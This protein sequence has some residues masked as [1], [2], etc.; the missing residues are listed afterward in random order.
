A[1]ASEIESRRSSGGSATE[2]VLLEASSRP[3]GNIRSTREEG[4]LYEWGPTGFLDNVPETVALAR[5]AGLEHRLTRANPA[6]ER[7]FVVK[8][9]RLCELPH[10]VVGFLLSG[11]L[12]PGGR[13]RVLGEPFVPARRDSSDESVFAFASRRIGREAA[14]VLVDA[15]V[16]GVWAGDSTK[17]SVASAF[18]KLVA[19][20]REHGG[21]VRGMVAT[22]RRRGDGGPSGPGGKLASFPDGLEELPK[23]IA[24]SLASSARFGTAASGLERTASGWRVHLSGAAPV[25]AD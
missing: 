4:Y 20:E 3:G 22:R 5:R 9:G 17:L 21:L 11:L 14:G 25:E 24:G 12:S 16:T 6:A 2:V 15:L 1:I 8:G 7:R 23:A 10:G 18:P 13:A 19:L